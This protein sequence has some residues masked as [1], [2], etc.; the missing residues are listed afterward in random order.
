MDTYSW[1]FITVGTI[2]L[3][4]MATPYFSFWGK[5][6]V[7]IYYGILSFLFIGMTHHINEKYSGIIPVPDAYWDEN[8]Q[9]A[10]TASNL[11]LLPFIGIL[12]YSYYHWFVNAHTISAKIMIALSM[13]PAA[14][15]VFFFYFI[16]NFGYGYRP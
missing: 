10:W 11:V 5:S 13:L 12:L 2:I 3:I 1:L 14:A 4:V 9:W 15:L 8:S 7:V 16:F 6:L